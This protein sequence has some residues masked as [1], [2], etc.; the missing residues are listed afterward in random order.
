MGGIPGSYDETMFN[1]TGNCQCFPARPHHF[2]LSLFC[3]AVAQP[4]RFT[5]VPLTTS[6]SLPPVSPSFPVSYLSVCP[7][8]L[9]SF[10][11]SLPLP[12]S[13][14]VFSHCFSASPPVPHLSLTSLSPSSSHFVT[15]PFLLPYHLFSPV[16]SPAPSP[17]A[18][19]ARVPNLC[20]LPFPQVL[21][22]SAVETG[23]VSQT[24]SGDITVSGDLSSAEPSSGVATARF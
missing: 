7:A 2:S 15:L 9:S 16:L 19:P 17:R 8:L 13:F 5:A 6:L 11:S 4:P 20:Q 24:H 3:L 23:R 14:S 18:P 1:V 10:P 21:T 12:R 22:I